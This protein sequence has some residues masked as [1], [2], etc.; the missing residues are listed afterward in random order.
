MNT[1]QVDGVIVISVATLKSALAVVFGS[2]GDILECW[3][4]QR[5]GQPDNNE[6]Q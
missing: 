4:S 3:I 6:L 1:G 5:F 2:A